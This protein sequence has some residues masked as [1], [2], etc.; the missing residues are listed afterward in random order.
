VQKKETHFLQLH[1]LLVIVQNTH[2]I[3]EGV[4]NNETQSIESR[5]NQQP[6]GPVHLLTKTKQARVDTGGDENVGEGQ[7][8]PFRDLWWCNVLAA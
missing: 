2:L 1:R 5:G 4:T 8:N 6:V 7:K 3:R